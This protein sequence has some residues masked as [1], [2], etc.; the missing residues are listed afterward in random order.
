VSRRVRVFLAIGVAVAVIVV[1]GVVVAS[2]VLTNQ[3]NHVVAQTDLFGTENPPASSAAPGPSGSP[4]PTPYGTALAGPLNLLIVGVDTRVSVPGWQ[5]HS[6][7]VMIMHVTADLQHAYLFSLP[8]DLVVQIP[9][10]APSHF[11]GER[12]KL[13]H[14]MSFGSHLPGTNRYNPAQGFQLLALTITK[15]T[16]ITFNGGAILTFNGLRDLVT[17]I[18]GIDLYVDQQVV[19][20]H[21]RPDGRPRTPSAGAL[22]GYVGPQAVY[23]VGVHHLVGWQALDYSRQRYTPGG[24]Y[25]RQRHQ[26][27]VIKAIMTKVLA[28]NLLTN[29][30]RMTSIL[31]ALGG[32][33]EFVFDGRGH[34]FLDYVYSLRNLSPGGVVLIG[35]PGGGVYSGSTYLGEQLYAPASSFFLA[36]R[37]DQV[38]AFVVAHPSMVNKDHPIP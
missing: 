22:H 7:A 37:Q 8:R 20:I 26:R 17:A 23:P 27:Q 13:T 11:P 18:G 2:R 16:G 34:Q 30:G 10:F 38:A 19:S 1:A 36:V 6:D 9:P 5:P 24:D 29:L 21:R 28:A 3:I 25:T 12:T 4:A 33:S 31:H 35:L 15:Y 32:R 14:A